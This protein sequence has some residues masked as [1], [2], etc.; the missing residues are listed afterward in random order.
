MNVP[1]S[2]LPRVRKAAPEFYDTLYWH[3]SWPGL[4]WRFLTDPKLSLYSRV[5]RERPV[6]K[7]ATPEPAANVKAE[8]EAL[9]VDGETV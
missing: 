8:A 7:A 2:R 5:I 6:P 9:A 3:R 1:W 4:M